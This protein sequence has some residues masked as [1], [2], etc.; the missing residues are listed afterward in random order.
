MRNQFWYVKEILTN[1]NRKEGEEAV[2]VK[3]YDSFNINY[4]LRTFH[5]PKGFVVMLTDGHEAADDVR[6]PKMNKKGEVDGIEIKRQRDWYVS[7]IPLLKEDMERFKRISE[8]Y[9]EQVPQPSPQ[10]DEPLEVTE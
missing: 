6:V 3:L 5:G 2:Y 10:P 8:I 7:E 4:V 9:E 1:P